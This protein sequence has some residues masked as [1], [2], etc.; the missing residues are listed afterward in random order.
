[1]PAYVKPEWAATF[2]DRPMGNSRMTDGKKLK[3]D[4]EAYDVAREQ[5]EADKAADR[6][7][8][9]Q[10]AEYLAAVE[11]QDAYDAAHE[12]LRQRVDRIALCGQVPINAAGTAGDYALPLRN[13]DGSIGFTFDPDPTFADYKRRLGM[14]QTPGVLVVGVA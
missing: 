1:M 11:A 13:A 6:E 5:W 3:A 4:Q 7:A 10:S 9:Y 12:A 2:G 14:V 8:F